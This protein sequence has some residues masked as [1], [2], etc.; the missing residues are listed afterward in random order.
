MITRSKWSLTIPTPVQEYPSSYRL[1]D[2][3]VRNLRLSEPKLMKGWLVVDVLE[4]FQSFGVEVDRVDIGL[5]LIG[6][7]RSPYITLNL[8]YEVYFTDRVTYYVFFKSCLQ[9]IIIIVM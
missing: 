4:P 2:S 9:S 7:D 6:L 1:V 3:P 5:L 8:L